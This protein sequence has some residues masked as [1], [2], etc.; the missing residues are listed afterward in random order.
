[1]VQVTRNDH[2]AARAQIAAPHVTRL[3]ECSSPDPA[4]RAAMGVSGMPA[5][6][7]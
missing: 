3:G 5:A 4:D 2:R 7:A 6:A 1:M